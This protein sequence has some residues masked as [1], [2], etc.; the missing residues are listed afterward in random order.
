[1]N[2]IAAL[3]AGV[4]CALALGAQEL[5]VNLTLNSD[6]VEGTNKQ[7]FTTLENLS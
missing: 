3:I 6:K 4:L 2:R 5:N 1:M 7:V